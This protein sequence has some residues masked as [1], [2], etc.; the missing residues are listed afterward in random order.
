MINTILVVKYYIIAIA[1]SLIGFSKIL[2]VQNHNIL[3]LVCVMIAGILIGI[4]LIVIGLKK[5][6]FIKN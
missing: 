4:T 6:F 2:E 5:G 3:S 1:A